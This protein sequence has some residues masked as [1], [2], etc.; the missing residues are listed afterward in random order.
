MSLSKENLNKINFSILEKFDY[1]WIAGGA[2]SNVLQGNQV[3]DIDIFFPNEKSRQA[4]VKKI[5][6]MGA[7]KIESHP[8]SDK[9]ELNGKT[10]DL[11]HAGRTPEETIT[12]FDWTICCA[13]IDSKSNF[14][15]HEHFFEH[16]GIKKLHFI[17]NSSSVHQLTFKNKVKRLSKYLEKGVLIEKNILQYWLSRMISD[18]NKLKNKRKLK[19]IEINILKF[20]IDNLK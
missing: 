10:Y 17:G 12:N 20:K 5:I 9:F 2:I 16:T 1:C 14:Y 4:A 8:L 18:H 11:T 3:S 15:C 7:K 19:S 13:A 6:Y